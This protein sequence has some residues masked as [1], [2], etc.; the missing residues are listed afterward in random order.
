MRSAVPD[1]VES[2]AGLMYKMVTMVPPGEAV[3]AGVN[4]CHLL[5]KPGTFVITWPRAYHAGFSHGVNCAESSNFATPDW[6]VKLDST[7]P[8]STARCTLPTSAA[9]HDA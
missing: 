1:L 6:S 8:A 4:V 9:A 5:Q 3:K 2:E 7:R